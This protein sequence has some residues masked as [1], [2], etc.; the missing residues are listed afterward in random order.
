MGVENLE[1]RPGQARWIVTDGKSN[2]AMTLDDLCLSLT[3]DWTGAQ[4]SVLA[5]KSP[6]PHMT[7]P[8][9][10]A[11]AADALPPIV[12][13]VEDDCDTLEIYSSYF[14]SAGLWVATATNPTEGRAHAREL[15]PNLVVTDIGFGGEP[16]GVDLVRAIKHDVQTAHIPVMVLSGTAVEDL[17]PDT[18]R[19]A[20]LVLLKP[21]MPDVLLTRGQALITASSTLR[22]RSNAAL[23]R[24]YSLLDENLAARQRGREFVEKLGKR[25]RACPKCGSALEWLERGT[26]SGV[27]YDY[28]RWCLKGCGLYCYDRRAGD[29]IKL[30]G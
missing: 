17:P 26:I 28:Y 29:W 5:T 15:Q 2:Y 27:E 3:R 22:A 13:L 10:E 20:D 8:F 4:D 24:A 9:H 16:T 18:R 12:L 21:V 19:E 25:T 7:S 1:S 14:E 11:A 23:E 6:G 30:A